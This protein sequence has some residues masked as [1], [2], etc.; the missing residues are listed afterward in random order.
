MK[1]NN[2]CHAV[3]AMLLT[4]RQSSHVGSKGLVDGDELCSFESTSD[5]SLTLYLPFNPFTGE[6][7]HFLGS[8]PEHICHFSSLS[9]FC[10][11]C[12]TISRRAAGR[13][14][15][16]HPKQNIEGELKWL[17]CQILCIKVHQ[18]VTGKNAVRQVKG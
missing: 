7:L 16:L 4:Q 5:F 13:L 2:T 3:L 11:G 6:Q 12:K 14:I 18:N 8:V 17:T 9:I 15:V 1:I 10:L